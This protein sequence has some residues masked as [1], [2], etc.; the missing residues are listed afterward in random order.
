MHEFEADLARATAL[1]E[2]AQAADRLVAQHFAATPLYLAT[3]LTTRVLPRTVAIVAEEVNTVGEFTIRRL[4]W[5][6]E[7]EV[8]TDPQ[9]QRDP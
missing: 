5:V 8:Y 4:A 9:A 1:R 3:M 6:A 2:H 7:G